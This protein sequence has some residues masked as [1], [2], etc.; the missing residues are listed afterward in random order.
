MLE[1]IGSVAYCL[2]PPPESMIYNDDIPWVPEF[3]WGVG[4]DGAE[5]SCPHSPQCTL[6]PL[7]SK[8]GM[9]WVPE[10]IVERR[11]RKRAI[12]QL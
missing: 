5:V 2:H 10:D 3:V 7:A 1:Q 12:C 9:A 6:P 11:V 4:M 8:G